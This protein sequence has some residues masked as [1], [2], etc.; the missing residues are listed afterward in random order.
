[1]QGDADPNIDPCPLCGY[2]LKRDENFIRCIICG[3]RIF[4]E[5]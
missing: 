3:S 4:P 2:E 1:M 5:K